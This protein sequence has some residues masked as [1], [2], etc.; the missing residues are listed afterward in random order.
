MLF[1]QV[2]EEE[3]DM[4]GEN[5]KKALF[6][7]TVIDCTGQPPL[8][9]AAILVEGEHIT[10]VGPR[11]EVFPAGQRP[12]G[13]EIIDLDGSYALPGLMDMHKHLGCISPDPTRIHQTESEAAFTLRCYRDCMDLLNDGL[14]T[15]R[16][17]GLAGNYVDL[18]LKEAINMGLLLGPRIFGGGI[19]IEPTGGHGASGREPRPWEADG[20]VGFREATRERLKAGVDLIKIVISGGLAGIRYGPEVTE[21]LPEEVR[22]VTEVA[23]RAGKRVAAHAGSAQGVIE[24]IKA[25]LDCV[26]HGYL[27][28]DEAAQLMAERGIYYVPT[29]AI[30]QDETWWEEDKW[31]E[32]R[33]EKARSMAPGHLAAFKA[34]LRAG[35]KIACGTDRTL[36][37]ERHT[38]YKEGGEGGYP[39]VMPR[40]VPGHITEMEIMAE[41]GLSPMR[42]LRA[43]TQ[44]AAELCQAE[45]RLGTLEKGKLADIVAVKGNPLEDI[46]NLRNIRFV[47]KGGQVIRNSIRPA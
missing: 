24:A 23:H 35:V 47:M 12:E 25:G 26:E 7:C 14:T 43:A 38:E 46:S 34:A 2:S 8:K 36:H 11:A 15:I 42:T 16:V 32:W 29:L 30:T 13:Y 4:M 19:H 40:A 31:P 18:E 21:M 3:E 22:A 27:L 33:R 44:E 39:I 10:A 20:V 5:M 1:R 6:N 41:A 17:V 37:I 9:E 45:D 28:D